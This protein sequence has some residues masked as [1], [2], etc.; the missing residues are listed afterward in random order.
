MSALL[1]LTLA[2]LT[3]LPAPTPASPALV[4]TTWT[5]QTVQPAGNAPITPGAPLTRPTLTLTGSGPDLTVGGSTGCSALTGAARLGA[6]GP[7]KTATLLLRGVQGGDTDHCTD[8]ALALR[9]DYLNL[10]RATTRYALNGDTLTL[11]A[12]KGRLTFRAL[13]ARP[14]APVNISLNGAWTVTRLN[15]AGRDLPT[16]SLLNVSFDGPKVTLGGAVGCNALRGTG[17]LLGGPARVTFGPVSSTRMACPV[18]QAQAETAL[19]ALLRAP[20]S[21]TQ[22]GSSLTLSG[23][24]GTLTLTRGPQPAATPATTPTAPDPAATYTLT[25]VNGAPAPA[26]ARPVSLTFR[27][28]R[29]GGVD[30]CNNVGAPYALRGAVSG[31]AV[32]TLTGPAFT[33]RVAC[34]ETGVNLIGLLDRAPTLT[35]QG[36]AGRGQTLTLTV[37][38]TA[39]APAERWEFQAR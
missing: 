16:S 9:E 26:T 7:L 18:P 37:P 11:S 33:T 23:A 13:E 4:G 21:V 24:G 20:L 39:D 35:V 3:S 32:L 14:A 19:L 1:P 36:A 28:G 15:A 38:A 29:V 34:P 22:A 2:V 6:A 25:R 17:A 27:D 5:L 31:G 8:A 30:G 12:G 10:L